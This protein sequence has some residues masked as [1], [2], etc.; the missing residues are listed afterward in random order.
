M[1]VVG[2]RIQKEFLWGCSIYL[3]ELARQRTSKGVVRNEE[4]RQILGSDLED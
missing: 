4:S 2:R 1:L 3:V